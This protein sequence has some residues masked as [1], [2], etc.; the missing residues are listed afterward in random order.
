[1]TDAG[2]RN[3]WFRL[4]AKQG[5]QWVGRVRNRDFVRKNDSG[6]WLP[7]KQ[8]Y[9]MAR[10][11]AADLGAFETVRNRP[12]KCRLV[13]VKHS[14]KGRKHRYASGREQQNSTAR[15]CASRYRETALH[16]LRYDV[17]RMHGTITLMAWTPQG[18]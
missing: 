3:P 6:D 4:I 16:D 9:G 11:A 7:A 17:L 8:L 5:W 14:S 12:L 18:N 15:K 1:M 2:F 13:L 10:A